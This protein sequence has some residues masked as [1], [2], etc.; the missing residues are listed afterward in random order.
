MTD[1]SCLSTTDVP[2]H[3]PT[4]VTMLEMTKAKKNLRIDCEDC[5][6][7]GVGFMAGP[8]SFENSQ[9]SGP[10]PPCQNP[11]EFIERCQFR[12]RVPAFQCRELLAKG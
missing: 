1:R 11:E 6:M 7:C 5:L 12:P 8:L 2:A 9:Q 10:E 3:I 4:G